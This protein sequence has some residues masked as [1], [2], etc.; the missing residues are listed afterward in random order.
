MVIHSGRLQKLIITTPVCRY[1]IR[2]ELK[3]INGMVQMRYAPEYDL[4]GILCGDTGESVYK[5]ILKK[6]F[7]G[8][9][10]CGKNRFLTRE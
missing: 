7:P 1:G 2:Y 5:V 8:Y 10:C 4:R 6:M 3:L 9:E